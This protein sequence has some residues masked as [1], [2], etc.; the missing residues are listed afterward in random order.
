MCPEST[1]F[2]HVKYLCCRF[3]KTP[4]ALYPLRRAILSIGFQWQSKVVAPFSPFF[5]NYYVKH[6]LLNLSSSWIDT[7]H[8]GVGGGGLRWFSWEF[9][10]KYVR[11]H[12]LSR[13]TDNITGNIRHRT[14]TFKVKTH[15]CTKANTTKVNKTWALQQTT[16]S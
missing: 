3:W 2:R 8:R 7:E 9:A 10:S 15:H 5:N 14:K 11:E 1:M 4:G 16:G 13:G 6:V 12:R